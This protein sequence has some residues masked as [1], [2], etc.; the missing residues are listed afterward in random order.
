[1]ADD[2]KL[3]DYL[4]KVTTDLRQTRRRLQEAESATQEPIAIIGMSCRYPGG[5]RSPED[6]WRLV[7][8]GRDAIGPFPG[9]RGWDLGALFS[10]EPDRSGSS[11][12]HEG[13][14]VDGADE[15]DAAFFGISP[16]E[17]LA[18]DPQQRLLLELSW[19][20]FERAGIDPHTQRGNRV[21]VFA[22]TGSQDYEQLLNAHPDLSEA[23]GGTATSAAVL[24]G[25]VSYTFGLEGPAVSVDTACSSSLVALH[26]AAQALRQRE[27]GLALAGGVMVMA[28]PG[29]FVG[30]SRQGGLAVDGRCK[31]FSDN[32]DGTAWGE[33][34]GLLVLERLSDA[35]RNGHRVLAVVRG[36]AVNSDGASNGLTAPNGPSQQRVI[37]QALANAGLSA[38]EVDA[39]EAHGTGTTLGDPI[40]A[41]ALLATYGQ[42]R[43]ADRPLWLG[44]LKSN[45][46]HTQAAAGV[47]GV[48]KM[49]QA[50]RHGLLPKTLHVTEPS[51]H[52]DWTAGHVELL[53]EPVE[54]PEHEHPR[55]AGI[56]SFG[57][58][59]T[60]AHAVIEQAPAEE[61]AEDRA[62]PPIFAVSARTAVALRAQADRLRA[63][64]ETPG[65][66]EPAVV[67][68]ALATRAALEHR[69]VV[70]AEDRESVL[71]GLN[72]LADGET[73]S[74]LLQGHVQG[75]IAPAFF[76][77]DLETP[78]SLGWLLDAEPAFAIAV[79]ECAEAL[80]IEL[81]ALVRADTIADEMARPVWWAVQVSLAK[82]WASYGVEP[83]AVGG[84][85]V[86]AI[87]A[88]CITGALSLTEGAELAA[89]PEA[90][91]PDARPPA[92]GPTWYPA[93]PDGSVEQAVSAIRADGFEVFIELSPAATP[94]VADAV[95]DSALVA[96]PGADFHASLAGAYLRGVRV[97]WAADGARSVD[98]PTYPFQ[99]ERYWVDSPAEAA[100]VDPVSA[101]QLAADHPLLTAVV[102]EPE[103]GGVVLTGRL[104]AATRPWLA[105]H[106]VLGSVIF[107]GT[108]FVELAVRAGDQAGCPVLDELTLLTPLVLPE[109]GAVRIQVVVGGAGDAG[110]REVRVFSR[111]EGAAEDEPWLRHA[112]GTVSAGSL[113][114]VAEPWPPMNGTPVD[115]TGFYAGL[116]EVGLDYGP[117][118]RGLEA[119]WQADDAV[120]AEVT[121]PEGERGGDYGVHPALLDAALHA[122]SLMSTADD[123]A[124][125]PFAWSGV[126]LFATG[127]TALRVRIRP[128]RDGEFSLEATDPAGAPVLSVSSLLLRRASAEQLEGSRPGA[129]VFGV[130]WVP[131]AAAGTGPVEYGTWDELDGAVPG[132]VALPA[133]G[134][135]D[136][137]SVRAATAHVLGVLQSW[138][139]EE[140]FAD[141][142]LVVVTRGAAGLPG[143]DVSDLAGAA[144]WGLVRSAQ[145]EHPGRF[146]LLDADAGLSAVLPATLASDEPQ[147]LV[148][149][150]VVHAARLTRVPADRN[151]PAV[152][153]DGT[154]LITG[155]TGA[156]GRVVARHLVAEH[157]VRSL[158]LLGRRGIAA[159]GMGELVAE[160]A[161]AGAAVEV[162]ACD[163]AD[164]DA[165]REVLADA[166]VRG[167]VHAAG[168]L[169][170]GVLSSLTPERLER[171]LRPKVDAALNLHE[172]T[173][174]LPLTAFVLFS[175]ASGVFGAPGQGNYAAANAFLDGLAE[176]RRV[177]GLP[178]QSLAWGL[179]SGSGG[180]GGTLDG[181][182]QARISRGG[183]LGL[184]TEDG[185]ELFDT[186]MGA[187]PAALV[188]A[189]LDLAELRAQGDAL[190]SLLRGLVPPARRNAASGSGSSRILALPP[191]EREGA[192]LDLVLTVVANVLGYASSGAVEPGRA[193]RELGFDSLTS[194]EFRNQLGEAIGL[195]LPMTLVFDY[196]NPV[197]LA[198]FVLDE[199]SGSA[200]TA[201]AATTVAPITDDEPIAIV[202]MACRYPGGVRSPED[203]W[204]LVVQGR[205]AIGEFPAD[206]GWDVERL[207][208]PDS[209]RP[210]TSY[211]RHGGFLYGAGEFDPEFFG[212]S[213]NEALIMDPQQRLLLEA[214]WELFERAGI[215]PGSLKGSAT[216]VFTGLMYHD[217]AGSTSTGAIA[218]GRV[219][220]VYGL[221]GPAVTVDTACSSSLVGLH[222]AVQSLR[223]GECSLALAGGATVMATPELF[224]EFSRQRGLAKDGRAK[225]FAAATDGTSWGEG[226]GL[227][228]VERLSDARRLGHPVLAVVAGSAVNQDGASNGLTA[229]NGPSQVRVIRQAL[230]SAGL[231]SSDV[232]AVEAHGTGT[233][234]GD[235][236]EAQ[237]LL[238]AY[239]QER[240]EP[241]WLGS[242]KSNMGHTQAAAGVAGI[243]K[244]VQA[245]RHGVLPKTLHVDEPTP[246][247]DWSSGAVELL[248]ESRA[249]PER[250]RARRAGVSS[251]G[252]SGTNA[253]V[254]VEEAPADG[255]AFLFSGQGAQRLGMGRELYETYPAFAAAF[256]AVCAELDPSLREVIW[257]DDPELLNQTEWAQPGLFAVE[258]ALFRLVES[259]GIRPDFVAGHSIGE[260]AAAHVAGV[261]SLSDA[262]AL[263]TAR[264]RLMQAL[265]TGGAMVAVQA[266]EQ[267]VLPLLSDQVSIAAIN[268]PEAVVLSG[269][270]AAVLAVANQLSGKST[271]LKVSHAFH[272]PLMEPMLAE[273]AAVVEQLSLREAVLPFV[274]SALEADV[275]S[276]DYWVRHVREPVRFADA[277]RELESRGVAR[278]VELGPAAVLSLL[279]PRCVSEG[280]FEATAEFIERV[281]PRAVPW[282]LSAKNEEG[283]R[284]QAAS[285]LSWPENNN[286]DVAYSLATSRPSLDHRAAVVGTSRDEL[287]QG[288][289]AFAAG[290]SS[291]GV[292]RGVAREHGGTAFVFSGQGAQRL[293]MGRELYETYPAFAAAFDAVCAELDPKLREVI[294][295]DDSDLVNQTEWVQPGLFAV[296]VA[297]FR[298]V[299]SWGVRPDFVAGHSIGEIAAAHV[300]G[301]L[302]LSDAAALVTARGRLM[303]ALP[304]GGAM[305]AVQASEQQVLPLLSDQVAIAAINGPEAVVLSG[306]EAAVLKVADA[307]G[308]K[309]TRL[310]VSHAFHSPL[311]E[312][313]LA[314][315]AA[316]VE[317]LSLREAVLPFVSSAL[318]AD[319]TS[320]NYW[321][322]HVR[323]P[324]RFA[325]AVRLLEERGVTTFVEV[326]PDAVLSSLG[327]FTPLQRRNKSE[328]LE[329]VTA[330]AN[331]HTRGVPVDWHAFHDGR[332]RRV[333][334]PTYSF[335]H[336]RYWLNTQDYWRDAWAG[337]TSGL[338]DVTS[339]GLEAAEHP[340][341]GAVVPGAES[342]TVVLTGKVSPATDSWLADHVVLGSV[343]F[344]GT[345]FVELAMRAADQVGCTVLGE[346]TLE[347]PLVLPDDGVALQVVVGEPGPSGAR[348]VSIH[349]R[350][351]DLPWV[352]HATGTLADEAPVTPATWS[353]PTGTPIDLTGWYANLAEAGLDYGPVFRGLQSA[354]RTDTEVFAEVRLPAGAE[355][356]GFGLHPALLDAC[357]HTIGLLDQHDTPVLPF[358]WTGVRWYATGAAAVRVRVTRTGPSSVALSI[359]DEQGR[360]VAEVES[361]ALR[362]V[363][364]EQLAE[365]RRGL[366][367]SL[368]QVDWSPLPPA[369]AAPVPVQTWDSLNG[370]VP[371]VVVLPGGGTGEPVS[372]V[373]GR[374]LTVLQ[375]WLEDDRFA[376]S[377]LV[378]S[379]REAV[380]LA[381]EGVSDL[382]AAAVWGLVRSAQSEHPGRF[383]L[384]D[385]DAKSEL[386]AVLPAVVR[387][388]EP[389]V[390]VR[391]GVPHLARLVRVP[392][393]PTE[394]AEHFGPEGTVLIT[395]GTGALGALVARH[396]VEA[397]GVRSLLLAGRRG[398]A[399]PGVD[400]LVAELT[401]LGA[402]V[403][404]VACD[405]ADRDA[406]REV[407]ADAPVRGVVHAAG[408]LDDG[409]LSS[410]TPERLERVLRPKVDAALNLHELTADLPL[411]AFVLFSSAAG[412][413]GA[414]GQANYAA[415]NAFL[416][417]LAEHRRAEG[418]PAQ[419]LA[420]GLWSGSGGMSGD[421]DRQRMNRSGVDGL[422]AEEGLAL[423]D[424][425]TRMDTPVLVPMRLDVK[426]FADG[427]FP[428][429]LRTLVPTRR[430]RAADSGAAVA[431]RARLA[432][433]SESDR[434]AALLDLIRAEAAALLGHA[435]PDAI[436]PGRAFTELGFDSLT[437]VE[438]RN[439]LNGATGLNLPPT[440]VFD[441]PNGQALATHLG[442]LLGDSGGDADPD[443]EIRRVLRS[444]P[445]DLL[446]ETGLLG[447]LLELGGG[448]GAPVLNTD[449]AIDEMDADSLIGLA[450]EGLDSDASHPA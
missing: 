64:L 410:L 399:A 275:T 168:V 51:S 425:A 93:S 299:E 408:V 198:R 183:F 85:G 369:D 314:E 108:G 65:A 173:A 300:A 252:I 259:W 161:G 82:L 94:R 152:T 308:C 330:V 360:P 22:G 158:L 49:V 215:D 234:L 103:S 348:P 205:D 334:L 68:S 76:C 175:S 379:T 336:Q 372:L 412:V 20:A 431:T 290:R 116:A 193:F 60:N 375:T 232:D 423:F 429:M 265:P 407:L 174:D 349:S 98:L 117:A 62:V 159:P 233:S 230:G 122:V 370:V 235:P 55:R 437:S 131:L 14:F 92:S 273:F 154:V 391:D 120:F 163:A 376:S 128:V 77:P 395:G 269:E 444:I 439:A 409:V 309:K 338:G 166:P 342:D 393:E 384:V 221:E 367:E 311:M 171:V 40:E 260:I 207:F 274:S 246:R 114:A 433:L 101:G 244:M 426:A 435:G 190:P 33:G 421:A 347:A 256:D 329:L 86:G 99:R 396:L 355:D 106:R 43:T 95:T 216:G 63:L 21:G 361:L 35:Q 29:V 416:D 179:W 371:E 214:S 53:T 145:S 442:A 346:L 301:V 419:S 155:A 150:G 146:V 377:T 133:G 276:P 255:L 449:D 418:L 438:F 196:P 12:A 306:E 333:D 307:L 352:R 80:G 239:G 345:G 291:A 36:T 326:G 124:M 75:E 294:W 363:S 443:E 48:I 110:A 392:D 390:A 323:E 428:A 23:Y 189:K 405:A 59:G 447:R 403:S 231:S 263:V 139:A 411:T 332:A 445:L 335:Q 58:S 337:S 267:E 69:A 142:K 241:L 271:R 74:N 170:D 89:A 270:E 19:E 366:H 424:T 436:D 427:D 236:I 343:V 365:A 420:W 107:P 229:P 297:L 397:R 1:M 368:F 143:E 312:P 137:D 180:M 264:G 247:V 295:G 31:S 18:M 339:A 382:A 319:V 96:A 10:T 3:L 44:S 364:A 141:S 204:E 284:A 237:A 87:A 164:R 430:R 185:L 27:C 165:L 115:L 149:D 218:S 50:M 123:G 90:G 17:A 72:A 203:L 388:G 250:G 293:G 432:E 286:A 195:R 389:Q 52:V 111:A 217:Y 42:G 324:V 224:V 446:R 248:T 310:K 344:P 373:V 11:Y 387:S 91:P 228:L 84:I 200:Q 220:Y 434:A 385:V 197:A 318:E 304:T 285:L 169:D 186:A 378:V 303:Q 201:V 254:I 374:V 88:A 157:G 315:F 8:D 281:R 172:L 176:H 321:V 140:R 383:V 414:P 5:V 167:V 398:S 400:E 292:V 194:V 422:D 283:L 251:F 328:E 322:R 177:N 138:V 192:V 119:A 357:L 136:A 222:L 380:S 261:L 56:S 39:V 282:V 356:T 28:T 13:G 79:G 187:A 350:D 279:G 104:S 394:P 440:L 4:K 402:A 34:A 97:D 160:L 401:G 289:S 109:T 25:R 57:V 272:S 70:F 182:D 341:L 148:R 415:A 351:A 386:S 147:V 81:A 71:T 313:M 417:G 118:F 127:A 441:H 209:V 151:E 317:Q 113:E 249:W 188:T 38:S 406:L 24:A 153:F 126:R 16:K 316:V 15:F 32:A 121:L 245:M 223:S 78:R 2:G 178:A 9:D 211:V 100:A 242:I 227:L 353:L 73:A 280:T 132:V 277:V 358:A 238:T 7:A 258:V 47:G 253:H 130:E 206:R 359:E 112:T 243:I 320:P 404:V 83:S 325:D 212:I 6:L 184:S 26:L 262:A 331:I 287:I 208:D 413:L 448:G 219:S 381:G 288:L 354:W 41:Q 46:G 225:S 266:S 302:S 210:N 45:L 162:V 298:L 296:E 202:S 213:P 362:A 54:W 67:T 129:P 134:G 268:G 305:V 450:L 61:P 125:L 240:D 199:L 327:G 257:G 102:A 105:D 144:V 278:Y 66:P 340:L 191:A 156:L 135:V 181:A 30:F 37:R 226:V